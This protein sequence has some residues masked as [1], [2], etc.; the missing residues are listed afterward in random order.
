MSGIRVRAEIPAEA[1]IL[2]NDLR[3]LQ[4]QIES[5]PGP[6]LHQDHDFIGE[7]VTLRTCMAGCRRPCGC[8]TGDRAI[9]G[10]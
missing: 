3:I 5:L 2:L 9:A 7:Q 10:G 6:R 8:L 1:K 4:A